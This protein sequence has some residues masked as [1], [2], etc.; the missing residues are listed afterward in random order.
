MEEKDVLAA[1]EE[2]KREQARA[3]RYREWEDWVMA[4][5]LTRPHRSSTQLRCDVSAVLV[6]PDGCALPDSFRRTRLEWCEPPGQQGQPQSTFRLSKE[7]QQSAVARSEGSEHGDGQEALAHE[8]APPTPV[9]K[10]PEDKPGA[11]PSSGDGRAE[12]RGQ[13]RG[14]V[15]KG[16]SE[17]V[18]S[19]SVQAIDL[20][21]PP[22]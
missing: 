5:S 12:I 16:A 19:A 2:F 11:G 9:K 15:L 17:G 20:D 4:E 6:G 21:T 10:E 7:E 22:A 8:V 13:D 18:G 14:L 1:V 3:K